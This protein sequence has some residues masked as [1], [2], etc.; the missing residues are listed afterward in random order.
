MDIDVS[1]KTGGDLLP[2]ANLRPQI[3]AAIKGIAVGISPRD[4]VLNKR[5]H[6]QINNAI[7]KMFT[8][9]GISFLVIGE[10]SSV[11]I[12]RWHY[13]GF[14]LPKDMATMDRCKSWLNNVIG[15]TV[16]EQIHHETNY[17]DYMLKCY[18]NNIVCD[19]V[20]PFRKESVCTNIYIIC[21]YIKLCKKM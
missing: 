11:G 17:V 2:L 14:C 7:K 20:Q 12:H 13:H 15:R 9:C 16:T 5:T 1:T 21:E 18:E 6:K 8:R 10:W 4:D 19:T 3:V